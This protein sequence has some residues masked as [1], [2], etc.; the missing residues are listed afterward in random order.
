M[1]N[2]LLN[3]LEQQITPPKRLTSDQKHLKGYLFDSLVFRY[4]LALENSLESEIQKILNINDDWSKD[5]AMRLATRNQ[6]RNLMR[7]IDILNEAIGE[8]D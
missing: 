2:K 3:E 8:H 6:Q 7:F 1:E 5:K 4:Q